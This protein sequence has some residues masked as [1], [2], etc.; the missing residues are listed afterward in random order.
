MPCRDA[1]AA[2]SDASQRLLQ[3]FTRKNDAV[4]RLLGNFVLAYQKCNYILD[5]SFSTGITL[6]TAPD[7]G[8]FHE[9]ADCVEAP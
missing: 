9:S 5:K 6:H 1:I 4:R 7:E 3:P 8:G 2:H